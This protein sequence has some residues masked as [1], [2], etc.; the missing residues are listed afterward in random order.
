MME[1]IRTIVSDTMC[2]FIKASPKASRVEILKKTLVRARRRGYSKEVIR[3][4]LD[5]IEV[6]LKVEALHKL[7]ELEQT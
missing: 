1:E 7:R 2:I 5:R 6:E 3:Y 4:I